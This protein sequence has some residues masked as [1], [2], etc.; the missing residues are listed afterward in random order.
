MKGINYEVHLGYPGTG[1]R[2][3]VLLLILKAFNKDELGIGLRMM[4][5]QIGTTEMMDVVSSKN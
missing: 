4:M 5:R 1:L 2:C 3:I